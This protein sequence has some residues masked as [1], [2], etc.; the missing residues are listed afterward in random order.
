VT[1]ERI[2]DGN[3]LDDPVMA[4]GVLPGFY[5]EAIAV[6]ENGAWPMSLSDYYPVDVAHLAEYAR[7]AKT[8]DGFARYCDDYVYE[9][10]AA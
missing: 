9:K 3:L 5:V 8:A 1:V 7:L 4:A 6:V 10:K 2:A